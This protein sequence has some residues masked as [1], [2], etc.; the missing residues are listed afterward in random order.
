LEKISDKHFIGLI[1]EVRG[2]AYLALNKP[3]NARESY[4]AALTEIPNA[5]VNRP[6]LQMKLD[7]LAT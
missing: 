7:N 2:D 5:E 6:I 4:R 1:N 3:T